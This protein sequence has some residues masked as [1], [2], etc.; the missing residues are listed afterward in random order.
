MP[1]DINWYYYKMPVKAS[2]FYAK[3]KQT[4]NNF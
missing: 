1:I 3:K 4:P 2:K